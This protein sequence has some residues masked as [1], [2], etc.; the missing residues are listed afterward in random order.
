MKEVVRQ[1][2][3]QGQGKHAKTPTSSPKRLCHVC[4]LISLTPSYLVR[5]RTR[6]KFG[7]RGESYST[8]W[9]S[10]QGRKPSIIPSASFWDQI[11]CTVAEMLSKVSIQSVDKH[12]PRTSASVGKHESQPRLDT[13]LMLLDQVHLYQHDS[14]TDSARSTAGPDSRPP[15]GL[16]ILV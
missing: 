16:D 6:P 12:V 7:R 10:R 13:T 5:A 8:R 15:C 4:L 9:L 3:N 11:P 14:Q 2:G 1:S